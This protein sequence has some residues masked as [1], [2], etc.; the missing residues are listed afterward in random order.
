MKKQQIKQQ[1]PTFKKAKVNFKEW[2]LIVNKIVNENKKSLSIFRKIINLIKKIEEDPEK[3]ICK[4]VIKR[5]DKKKLSFEDAYKLAQDSM[6]NIEKLKKELPSILLLFF[7]ALFALI[8]AIVFLILKIPHELTI[9]A[10]TQNFQWISALIIF[11]MSIIATSITLKRRDNFQWSLITNS[12]LSQAAGAYGS[13]K[14]HGKGGSLF[15]AFIAL[16][17]IRREIKKSSVKTKKK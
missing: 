1:Q 2:Y 11:F 16:D 5:F 12:I 9:K 17:L 8:F 10:W 13:V 7:G 14:N 6:Q 4:E 15:E 3:E